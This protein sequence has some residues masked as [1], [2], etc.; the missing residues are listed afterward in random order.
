MANLPPTAHIASDAYLSVVLSQDLVDFA[1]NLYP[2]AL[3]L[4]RLLVNI[5]D[6][7]RLDLNLAI[8]VL[9]QFRLF[10]AL[11]YVYVSVADYCSP[12][13]L[14]VG[15]SFARVRNANSVAQP[16]QTARAMGSSS[17]STSSLTNINNTEGSILRREPALSQS[18][19]VRKLFHF[20]TS[21]FAGAPF[22]VGLEKPDVGK[23]IP[24]LLRSCIFARRGA[25]RSSGTTSGGQATS[26]TSGRT[27]REVD[28][29]TNKSEEVLLE[30]EGR[31]SEEPPLIF[32]KLLQL[33]PCTLFRALSLLY[34]SEE[35]LFFKFGQVDPDRVSVEMEASEL[36]SP[37]GLLYAV[38][39]AVAQCLDKEPF[40]LSTSS[41]EGVNIQQESKFNEGFN[42]TNEGFSE[43]T[44]RE[45]LSE[46]NA[47]SKR[48]H[49]LSTYR[50]FVARAVAFG[51]R[52]GPDRCRS[53]VL[54]LLG[55]CG[56]GSFNSGGSQ[57]AEPLL[58]GSLVEAEELSLLV[59]GRCPDTDTCGL[60]ELAESLGFLKLQS[61]VHE[62]RG[63]FLRAV[64]AR[65]ELCN[66]TFVFEKAG[67]SCRAAA[68]ANSSIDSSEE[69]NK[70]GEEAEA[71]RAL[72]AYVEYLVL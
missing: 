6:V 23:V 47:R 20:I 11:T 9:S 60:L 26:G 34:I 67:R 57:H 43:M 15:E 7:F 65:I 28:L 66:R 56:A 69:K 44:S 71:R 68:G 22:L 50:W 42:Y 12:L 30:G 46:E 25:R 17:T 62:L 53:C 32:S 27:K 33:S 18:L 5:D 13:E 54:E 52:V 72:F 48:L 64:E 51:V 35:G 4:T 21:T 58:T 38:D 49:V 19:L 37:L 24:A 45:E 3:K 39:L 59:L 8:R 55:E 16:V 2:S 14:L 1:P 40:N 36:V 70:R 63:E 61:K 10:S 29:V 31:A 41:S